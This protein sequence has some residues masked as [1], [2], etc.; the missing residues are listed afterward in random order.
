MTRREFLRR[1]APLVAAGAVTPPFVATVARMLFG[2]KRYWDMGAAHQKAVDCRY[3]GIDY[4]K[5][6]SYGVEMV[7]QRD[8]VGNAL[9]VIEV[10]LVKE[11]LYP[12]HEFRVYRPVV[13]NQEEAQAS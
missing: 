9:R 11:P 2:K 12:G 6:P 13:K 7:W 4:A 8:P 1:S 5:G 3:Q 10:S